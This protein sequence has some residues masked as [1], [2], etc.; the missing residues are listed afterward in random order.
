MRSTLFKVEIRKSWTE[1]DGLPLLC[2]L[3]RSPASV[4]D[5][6]TG[7]LNQPFA[8]RSTINTTLS[9]PLQIDNLYRPIRWAV[10]RRVRLYAPNKY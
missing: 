3:K 5:V 7:A 10:I 8:A 6:I 1:Y 4:F 9:N 2:S